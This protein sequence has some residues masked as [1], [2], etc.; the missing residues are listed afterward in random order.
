MPKLLVVLS[1]EGDAAARD[2]A[3]HCAAIADRYDITVLA[4]RDRRP[5]F[6]AAGAAFRAFRPSGIFG[7]GAAISTL[8]RT[9]ERFG[10]DVVHVHGFAAASVALGTMPAAYAK[11]TIV[12]FHDPFRSGEL[13]RRLVERKL[14]GYIGRARAV[15]ATY[16]S[17]AES[18]QKRF[19]LPAVTVIPHGVDLP[20]ADVPLDRPPARDGPLLGWRGALAAD[21]AWEVAVDALAAARKR[22]PEARLAIAGDGRARQFVNAYVRTNGY[23]PYVTFLGAVDAAAFLANVDLVLVPI[24]RD[25]QPHAPLEALVAGIPVV[26]AN[27]G[28]LAEAVGA[29][30]TGWLVDDDAESFADGIADAWLQI[31]AAFAGAARQRSVASERYGR[32]VV[33]AAYLRLYEAG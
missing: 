31:D 14:P 12:T 2:A 17:L 23:A 24:S 3:E 16:T 5:A 9:I 22:Y 6:E 27:A 18:T 7:M 25:A 10:P 1:P 21:R 28:A 30:E 19:G 20:L 8:R 13:P 29:M 33:T 32:A 4:T 26:A 15:T 11:R